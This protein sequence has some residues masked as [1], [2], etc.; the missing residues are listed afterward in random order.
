MGF[1]IR[2]AMTLHNERQRAINRKYNIHSPF[3]DRINVNK[4]CVSG[5]TISMELYPDR[6]IETQQQN[7][8][9]LMNGNT[10]MLSPEKIKIICDIMEV[11]PNFIIGLPSIH[12]ADF[13]RLVKN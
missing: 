10:K 11:D 9:N 1:R 7:M 13:E 8:Y 12:D 2:D 6:R 5:K 4:G 3:G